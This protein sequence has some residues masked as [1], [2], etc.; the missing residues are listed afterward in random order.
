KGVSLLKEIPS[1]AD[2]VLTVVEQHHERYDGK[3]FPKQLQ[4]REIDPL[5]S[6]VR[7]SEELSLCLYPHLD[8]EIDVPTG[9]ERFC[10]TA[11]GQISAKLMSN[12]HEVFTT[13]D[14]VSG[15]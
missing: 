13:L 15:G 9:L 7:G 3:G 2:S 14:K 11:E 1:V 5:A 10:A 12:F 8:H 6:I 4:G